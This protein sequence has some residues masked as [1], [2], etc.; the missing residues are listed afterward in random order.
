MLYFFIYPLALDTVLAKDSINIL[1]VELTWN[2]QSCQQT[3]I[4]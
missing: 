4:S 1:Y 2:T 3:I